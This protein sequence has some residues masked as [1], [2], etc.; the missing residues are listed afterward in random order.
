MCGVSCSPKANVL[1]SKLV[2]GAL[3]TALDL[4]EMFPEE[5]LHVVVLP[6]VLTKVGACGAPMSHVGGWGGSVIAVHLIQ[7][8]GCGTVGVLSALPTVA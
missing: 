4:A 6:D 7:H 2:Y 5:Y 1:K 8:R 3:S